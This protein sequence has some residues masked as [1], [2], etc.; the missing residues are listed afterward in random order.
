[1]QKNN[2][3][4]TMGWYWLGGENRN[5]GAGQRRRRDSYAQGIA[6]GKLKIIRKPQGR[7][8]MAVGGE[9]AFI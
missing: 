4:G 9:K 5:R 7:G 3:E 6:F 1:L 8:P 2:G